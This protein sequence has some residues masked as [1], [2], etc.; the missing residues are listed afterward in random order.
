MNLRP[1]FSEGFGPAGCKLWDSAVLCRH[2]AVQNGFVFG[3]YR[4]F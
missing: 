3:Q 2:L 4:K 1:L